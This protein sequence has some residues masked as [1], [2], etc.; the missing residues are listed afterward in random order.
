VHTVAPSL[1]AYCGT[2]PLCI[3]WHHPFVHTV[4]PSL[5]AY[6]DTIPLCI[7][8]HRPFVH[9]MAPSLCAYCGT[10]PLC[11]LWHRPFRTVLA[12][13]FASSLGLPLLPRTE[14]DRDSS[15]IIA[16][17]YMLDCPGIESRRGR[18]FPHLSRPALG[19]THPPI[20]WVPGLSWG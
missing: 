2:I 19:P 9:T 18:D 13:W 4:A 11:I 3:L 8:W 17:R 1:C 6:C 15:V 12:N 7:L 16:T 20:Q 14:K 5:C 10:V